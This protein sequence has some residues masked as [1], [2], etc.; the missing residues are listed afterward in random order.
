MKL[1]QLNAAVWSLAA[2][3]VAADSDLLTA[4]AEGETDIGRLARSAQLAPDVTRHVL[5]VLEA[6]GFVVKNGDTLQL[7]DE[8][9]DLAKQLDWTRADLTATFGQANAFVMDARRSDLSH[10]WSHVDAE[11]IRAY[12]R[13][14]EILT[15]RMVS[16]FLEV[17]PDL[18]RLE[19][20]G[21]LLDVG[22]GAAGGLIGFCKRFPSLRA[23]GI[24]PLKAARIEART[25]ITAA[26]LGSRIEVRSSRVEELDE[27]GVYDLAHVASAHIGDDS[28]RVGLERV[29][30]ALVPGGYV[31]LAGW[32]QNADPR[33]AAVSRLRWRCW[34]GGPRSV[35]DLAQM[36][37]NAGFVDIREAP[38]RGDVVP[39][40]ARA[41]H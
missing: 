24:E 35:A 38:P 30:R 1:A 6:N 41:P 25:A 23:V 2:V 33:I 26:G 17:H 34:G 7:S 39:F 13:F 16:M 9:A 14:S 5:E 28:L 29:R 12:G 10:G 27:V 15:A 20:G 4:L 21:A 11:I 18:A 3:R 8:G 22:C 19:R 32:R 40:S 36:A 37:K 31:M